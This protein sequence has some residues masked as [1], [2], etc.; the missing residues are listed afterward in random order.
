MWIA[1]NE[2]W[3]VGLMRLSLL[4]V[5]LFSELTSEPVMQLDQSQR[6][7]EETKAQLARL[8][9]Q[10]NLAPSQKVKDDDISKVK[11]ERRS[12]S[13]TNNRSDSP[14][15]RCQLK[16]EQRPDSAKPSKNLQRDVK[17]EKGSSSTTSLQINDGSSQKKNQ[18]KPQIVIPAVNR[19]LPQPIN[20]HSGN[21]SNCSGLRPS[22]PVTANPNSSAKSRGDKSCKI[23][24]EQEAV[25]IH[26]K[27]KKRKF[28]IALSNFSSVPT[29]VIS[30]NK[31]VL[32]H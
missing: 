20:G 25:G 19:I 3:V 8:R 5:S 16:L 21:I 15:Q 26:A 10:H 30:I 27:G 32:L 18:S 17:D 29:A 1:I 12:I 24:S 22:E 9:G 2:T 6:K 11:T 14:Q 13:P 31:F 4:F 28:G 7:L 23:S